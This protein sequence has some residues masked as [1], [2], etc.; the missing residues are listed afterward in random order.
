MK[1]KFYGVVVFLIGQIRLKKRFRDYS[2]FCL[3]NG[4]LLL[5]YKL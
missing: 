3:I 5:V 1:I 2:I 4:N